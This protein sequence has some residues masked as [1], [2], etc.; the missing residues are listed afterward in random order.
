MLSVGKMN[1]LT[2]ARMADMGA[3]LESD[4]GEVLLPKKF[5]PDNLDVGD[6]VEAFVYVGYEDSLMATL[7]K[8]YAVVDDIAVLQVVDVTDHGAFLDWGLEKDLLLPYRRQLKP[9]VPGQKCVVKLLLDE[10]TGR[11]I[12]S[13]KLRRF[14]KENNTIMKAGDEV[15]ALFFDDAEVGYTAI[16]N[17]TFVGMLHKPDATDPI[18]IGETRSVY[19]KRVLP[20]G[21]TELSLRKVGYQAVVETRIIL[22]EALKEAGGFIACTDKSSPEEIRDRF[23][24]SKKAFKRVVG[25]LYK[26]KKIKLEDDGIRL[27]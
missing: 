3:Y 26:E 18:E 11:V 24:L 27:L 14:L 19:V 9:L 10:N 23:D 22:L 6:S 12:A 5:L 2:V 25:T 7:N 15:T 8:P 17:D 16:L 20:E 21:L 1:K 4:K 13:S